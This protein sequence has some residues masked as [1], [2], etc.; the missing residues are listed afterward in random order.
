MLYFGQRNYFACRYV[1]VSKLLNWA[2]SPPFNVHL[3]GVCSLTIHLSLP[4]HQPYANNAPHFYLC[5]TPFLSYRTDFPTALKT[6]LPYI[7]NSRLIFPE[8]NYIFTFPTLLQR[9]HLLL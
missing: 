7:S 9:A 5:S 1:S 3:L 2:N 8:L 4:L 6:S